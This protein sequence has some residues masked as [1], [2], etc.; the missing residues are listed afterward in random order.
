M[1]G[2][3]TR[4]DLV[5]RIQQLARPRVVKQQQFEYVYLFASVCPARGIEEAIEVPWVNKEI[6]VNQLEKISKATEK[7]RHVVVIMDGASWHTDDIASELNIVSVIKLP[8]YA[9]EIN[10]IEQVWNWLRQHCLANQSFTN[11]N[12][13]VSKVCSVWNDFLECRNRVTNMCERDWIGLI[14]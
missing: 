3:K 6:M 1:F 4:L 12:D 5:N 9:T 2:F 11:Y 8:P 10:P 14:S 13:I 7:D